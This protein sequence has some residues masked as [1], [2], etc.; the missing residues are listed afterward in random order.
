M[1][2]PRVVSNSDGAGA[3]PRSQVSRADLLR[4]LALATEPQRRE[5]AASL[6]WEL[7]PRR[8]ESLPVESNALPSRSS[9]ST[10]ATNQNAVPQTAASGGRWPADRFPSRFWRCV[11]TELLH[12]PAAP[13]TTY[14]SA[15]L[16]WTSPPEKAIVPRPLATWSR[17][18]PRLRSVLAGLFFSRELDL[19]RTVELLAEGRF[20]RPFPKRPLRRWGSTLQ[21]IVDRSPRLMP[22]FGDQ[23][24][25]VAQLRKILGPQ[26][27]EV[28][29]GS[30]PG[31]PTRR[32]LVRVGIGE[33]PLQPYRPPAPGSHV[34]VLGDLGGME[35]TA[36]DVRKRWLEF[37]RHIMECGAR[38]SALVPCDARRAGIDAARLYRIQ[39][40]NS[41]HS[42]RLG[43]DE[44]K[45]LADRLLSLVAFAVRVEPAFLRAC[46]LLL[47]N[48]SDPGLE[49]DV[50]QN[51][52]FIGR[53]SEAGTLGPPSVLE[54]LMRQFEQEPQAVRRAVVQVCRGLRNDIGPEVYFEELTRLSPATLRL[55]PEQD[56]RD[57]IAAW[58]FLHR[59]V[60]SA[61]LAIGHPVVDFARR[62]MARILVETQLNP[63]VGPYVSAIQQ[64]LVGTADGAPPPPPPTRVTA[65]QAGPELVLQ[66]ENE[67]S[68]APEW[69]PHS[70]LATLRTRGGWIEVRTS[71]PG[72][73]EPTENAPSIVRLTGT[74]AIRVPLPIAGEMTLRSDTERVR[75]R[76]ASRPAWVVKAGRDRFGLW[77]ECEVP[78]VDGEPVRVRWRWI[79]PG[80][81]W[82]GSP[83]DEPGRYK[84]EGPRHLVRLTRGY[85]MAE[86]PCTQALWQGVMQK[87]PSRF[88]DSRRPVE[89]ASWL[90][91]QEFIERLN[92]AVPLLRARLPTEAEWEY[93]CRA[94]CESA[95][96]RTPGATGQIEILGERNAPALDAIAWY[97]GNS[98][99]DFELKN[100]YDTSDWKEQQFP[101]KQA[102][103]H[104]VGQKL[105]NGWGLFDM[106]GNVWEWCDDEWSEYPVGEVVDP[107]HP[108]DRKQKV[109]PRVI[110][111]GS[112]NDR[113]R[114]VRCAVRYRR[115]AESRNVY[116][117][118][119]LV[120]VQ[121]GS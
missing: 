84:D 120:R 111:G 31:I 32:R 91:V 20:D 115:H 105:P 48:G 53:T 87:N 101:H 9:S 106:L 81:F 43:E 93:A 10:S 6:G 38:P 57:A 104:P 107:T 12:D 75:F 77:E 85:W 13:V 117:G 118:F 46:R 36:T 90:D 5:L 114:L 51:P 27:I 113:A 71:E 1:T 76:C 54:P 33:A 66:G 92:K 41:R 22:Y 47:D 26:N 68:P 98:G 14:E 44:R 73:G 116:L 7:S 64:R 59:E 67:T 83:N 56:W 29:Y 110:R 86:T 61:N 102:G 94:G 11:E 42:P 109:V 19:P 79:P 50:W 89:Q 70:R 40:W 24:L 108:G 37:G 69:S 8:Q 72:R 18:G 62:A 45:R 99:V 97:G 65:Y 119:R 80:T 103:T 3:F 2:S 121:E 88:V 95:L 112:W 34:L 15:R 4:L 52:A 78:A 55:V 49:A 60:Q 23:R 82:M 63:D 58:R 35:R 17:L 39:E 74:D 16:Q 96:Y 25:V 30:D 28:Y 100:G 21:L